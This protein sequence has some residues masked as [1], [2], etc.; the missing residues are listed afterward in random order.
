VS[1]SEEPA[2]LEH[3]GF[4][5]T[6][7]TGNAHQVSWGTQ[8]MWDYEKKGNRCGVLNCDPSYPGVE[9]G[10]VLVPDQQLATTQVPVQ[11]RKLIRTLSQYKTE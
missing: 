10:R 9:E 3:L 1:P 11:P 5:C 7:A 6:E 8:E 2:F 4:L